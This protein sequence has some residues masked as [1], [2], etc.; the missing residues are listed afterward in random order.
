MPK[1][2]AKLRTV[3]NGKPLISTKGSEIF[4]DGSPGGGMFGIVA[5]FANPKALLIL[6]LL[7]KSIHKTCKPYL[8]KLAKS[9]LTELMKPPGPEVGKK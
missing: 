6:A 8:A 5:S 3:Q 2:T 7:K 9:T 1:R 4:N